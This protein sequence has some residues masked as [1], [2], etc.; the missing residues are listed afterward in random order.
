MAESAAKA[1]TR[2]GRR[3]RET[4]ESFAAFGSHEGL[5]RRANVRSRCLEHDVPNGKEVNSSRS[6][7]KGSRYKVLC[8]LDYDRLM[9]LMILSRSSYVHQGHAW[10][11]NALESDKSRWE[12]A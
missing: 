4:R 3:R 1:R 9:S 12:I 7:F 8:R 5:P 2:G 11:T 6:S 10:P